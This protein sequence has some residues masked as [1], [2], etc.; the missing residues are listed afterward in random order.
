MIDEIV[1]TSLSHSETPVSALLDLIGEQR[2]KISGLKEGKFETLL[3]VARRMLARSYPLSEVIEI[4][5][6][7]EDELSKGGVI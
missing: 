3:S 4:T 5:R 2:G 7:T 6:L 1:R